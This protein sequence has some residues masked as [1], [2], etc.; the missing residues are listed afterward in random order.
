MRLVT[1]APAPPAQPPEFRSPLYVDCDGTLICDGEIRGE[2][3]AWVLANIEAGVE[4]Y[5]WSA[6]GTA[7]AR[8]IAERAGLAD[9]IAG[10]MGKP[11]V[12]LDDWGWSWT[13]FTDSVDPG[14]CGFF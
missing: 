7:Y 11:N 8:N 6:Q 1:L 13:R 3:V 10:A 9:L 4:V 12:I 5:V 14:R 2:V